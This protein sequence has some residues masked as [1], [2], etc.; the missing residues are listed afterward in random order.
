M[1]VKQQRIWWEFSSGGSN[2]F[3]IKIWIKKVLICKMAAGISHRAA[4]R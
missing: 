3:E 2:K 1:N 4:L